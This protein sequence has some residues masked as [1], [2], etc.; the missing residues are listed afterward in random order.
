[1]VVVAAVSFVGTVARPA[2]AIGKP[3]AAVAKPY[4]S[5]MALVQAHWSNA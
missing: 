1:M 4:R 5:T 2:A 3:A